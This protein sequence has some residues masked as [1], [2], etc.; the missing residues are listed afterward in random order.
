MKR[1]KFDCTECFADF[2]DDILEELDCDDI[3]TIIGHYEFAKALFR[4]LIFCGFDIGC[5]VELEEPDIDNYHNEY[6]VDIREGNVSVEKAW[7]EKNEWHDAGYLT[8]MSK[9][10]FVHEDCN[11]KVLEKI[12]SELVFEVAVENYGDDL[13][14]MDCDENCCDC[15]GCCGCD[16]G[17]CN[18]ET[19]E[20][21]DGDMFG[22]TAH[23]TNGD[24]YK[25]VSVYSSDRLT[26]RDIQSLLQGAGF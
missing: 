21:E 11:S 9:V 22:F 13:D 10:V 1:L 2:I 26:E 20:S 5:C 23:K 6:F 25:S 14:D 3:I 19:Y 4:E 8:C 7:H 15:D 18:L 17:N 24:G 12:N 16:D